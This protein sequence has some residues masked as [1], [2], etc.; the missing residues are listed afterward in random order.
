MLVLNV[1]TVTEIDASFVLQHLA[2]QHSRL[3]GCLLSGRFQI[4]QFLSFVVG[5]IHVIDQMEIEPGHI[6]KA[7]NFAERC[8]G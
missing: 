4:R 6:E 8:K 1:D 7:F 2:H 3:A 5:N